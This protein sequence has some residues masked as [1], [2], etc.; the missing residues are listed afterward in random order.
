MAK[1]YIIIFQSEAL[2]NLP[3]LGFLVWKQTIWQPRYVQDLAPAALSNLIPQ[4]ND[5]L[6]SVQNK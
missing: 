5:L 2:Q 6:N 3:K 1:K 4:E